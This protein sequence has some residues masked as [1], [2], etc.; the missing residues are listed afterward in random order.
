MYIL[1]L[2][3]VVDESGS[4]ISIE[5]KTST[6]ITVLMAIQ[7]IFFITLLFTALTNMVISPL[8]GLF[9][10]FPSLLSLIY[11]FVLNHLRRKADMDKDLATFK[12]VDGGI[13]VVHKKSSFWITLM[14]VIVYVG[15]AL[16]IVSLIA[17]MFV[18]YILAITSILLLIILIVIERVLRFLRTKLDFIGERFQVQTEEGVI[19]ELYKSRSFWITLA[20]ILVLID[21]IIFFVSAFM[22]L[23]G[24]LSYKDIFGYP[25]YYLP[26][27]L[28]HH[29]SNVVFGV[30]LLISAFLL[31]IQAT[32]LNF[33]RVRAHIRPIG[34]RTISEEAIGVKEII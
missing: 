23:T 3:H 12:T 18:S 30:S 33:L 2:Y 26:Y 17:F 19:I 4:L 25:L 24:M 8:A 11:V 6:I 34:R 9:N 10:L 15:I 20:L 21:A 22:L 16:T 31:L 7:I 27:S 5:E 32:I 28:I 14:L 29:A 13:I 1:V